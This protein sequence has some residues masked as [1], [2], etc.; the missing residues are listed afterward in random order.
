MLAVFLSYSQD[1]FY[2]K[3]IIPTIILAPF[4][5]IALIFSEAYLLAKR[6]S[7]AFNAVED[8][9]ESLK[10]INSSYR[11]FVPKELLK[12]LNKHDI[13]DIKLGDIAEEEMSLLYNEIRTF[14]DFSEKITSNL[15]ILF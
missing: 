15:S 3:R 11:F 2:T 10:K 13:I 6:Y 8:M 5:L 12:I 4:G 1:I 14:S 7:I 9:S